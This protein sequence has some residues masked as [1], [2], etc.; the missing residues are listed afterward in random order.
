MLS[1]SIALIILIAGYFTYGRF[2]SKVFGQD[3]AR[4][5]PVKQ[6][7][8]GVDFVELPTWK[9][10]LI[11]FLNIAGLGHIRRDNGCDVRIR[12]LFYGLF[13][14]PFSPVPFTTIFRVC[15]QCETMAHRCRKL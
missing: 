5:T 1:F 7:A 3:P 15:C 6:H 11:Q 4:P 10:F 13:S 2:V 8:D 14:A 12:L 9:V